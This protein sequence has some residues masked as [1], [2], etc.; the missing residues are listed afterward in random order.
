M[1]IVGGHGTTSTTM[2]WGLK[3]LADHPDAQT[4]LRTAL[5]TTFASSNSGTHNPSVQEIT[6]TQLPYLDAT[7]EE[8]IR[9][10]GTAAI[11]DRQA[12]VDT[13]ILGQRIPKGAVVSCL[14][15]G[16]SM[17]SPA[18]DID[19]ELRSPTS[20]DIKK[21]GRDRAWDPD[22][23]ALFKPE[24]W[25]NADGEFDAT[26]GPQLAFGLGARGCYGKRLVYVTMRIALALILL[27]F[28]LLPCPEALS[29]YRPILLTTNEPRQFYVRLRE[30]GGEEVEE[31]DLP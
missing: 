4:K 9:C 30:I 28:E 6:S 2:C 11:V 17:L 5:Q 27:N 15:A 31:E 29:S 12:L 19:E 1:F 8:I 26:A 21:S 24:R 7:I 20:Q 25:I 16:S 18:F 3:F 23:M 13:E 22:D 10:S 14:I